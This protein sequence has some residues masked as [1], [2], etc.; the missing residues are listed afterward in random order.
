MRA[1][2]AFAGIANRER[3]H[4]SFADGAALVPSKLSAGTQFR[5]R[6]KPDMHALGA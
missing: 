5:F 3:V 6:P 1:F 4:A 2:P